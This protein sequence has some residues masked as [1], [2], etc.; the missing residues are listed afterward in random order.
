MTIHRPDARPF[1]GLGLLSKVDRVNQA[2][3]LIAEKPADATKPTL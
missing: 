2:L 1:G 3:T